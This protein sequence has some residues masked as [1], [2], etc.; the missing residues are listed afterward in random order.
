MKWWTAEEERI[1][2][3]NEAI[4]ASLAQPKR[5]KQD[6]YHHHLGKM[7]RKSAGIPEVGDVVADQRSTRGGERTRK[8]TE[9]V[10]PEATQGSGRG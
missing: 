10:L 8:G 3:E 9:R 2:L 7:D 5:R 6:R 4:A 1:R